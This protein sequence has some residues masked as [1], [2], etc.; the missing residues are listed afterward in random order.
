MKITLT[1]I[2]WRNSDD[3]NVFNI[4]AIQSIELDE[5]TGIVTITGT[6]GTYKS[7]Y[8]HLTYGGGVTHF[9]FTC[10]RPYSTT[11]EYIDVAVFQHKGAV[12]VACGP[13]HCDE[14]F[15]NRCRNYCYGL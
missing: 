4:H 14:W 7:P 10:M 1:D 9:E 8:C 2:Y 3:S 5:D 6:S 12:A 13:K 11:L 15:E